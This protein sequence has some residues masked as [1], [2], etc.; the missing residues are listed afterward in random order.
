M[1]ISG[2]IISTLGAMT[3]LGGGFLAVPYLILAWD[4]GRQDAVLTSFV[5]ILGNSV[6]SSIGYLRSRLVDIRLAMIMFLSAMPAIV[7]GY[8]IL[9]RIQSDIFDLLF[10]AL[11]ITVTMY[12]L[13]TKGRGRGSANEQGKDEVRKGFPLL[14][15]PVSFLA[16]VLSSLFG[17]GGGAIFMPLQVVYMD[18]DV[19]RAVGTSMTVIAAIAIF[20]VF[21]VSGG[22]FDYGLA[23]PFLVGGLIGGQLGVQIV[24]RIKGRAI[25]YMLSLFLLVIA[26]YMGGSA[27][28]S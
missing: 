5:M 26:L 10:A 13:M 14:V 23:I 9:K 11:L 22:V 16:G 18:M 27:L 4:M 7:L 12:I 25:L 2:I 20:R 17:I 1:V 19:K 15:P 3:G 6:S 28:L 21:V 24:K 8:I